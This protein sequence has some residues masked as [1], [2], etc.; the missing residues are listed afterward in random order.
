MKLSNF[1][2]VLVVMLV[3]SC[4]TETDLKPRD[5]DVFWEETLNNMSLTIDYEAIKDTIV[6]NKKLSLFKVNSYDNVV[7]YAWVSEPLSDGEFPIKI[8]FS[9]L[10][11]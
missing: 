1:V 4:S 9:G 6:D 5:F 8:R 10:G 7:F 11:Q 3:T 2:L